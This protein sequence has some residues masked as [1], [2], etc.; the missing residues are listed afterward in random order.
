MIRDKNI[1]SEAKVMP[2][3]PSSDQNHGNTIFSEAIRPGT[4]RILE[5]VPSE[6]WLLG[7]VGFCTGIYVV[8]RLFVFNFNDQGFG[9]QVPSNIYTQ[10]L[11]I[12]LITFISVIWDYTELIFWPH[13]LHYEKPYRAYD[14]LV[15]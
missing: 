12:R 3:K 5:W 14:T 7:S 15:I 2:L 11:G 4:T 1:T 8:L 6:L 10:N 13:R 9:V